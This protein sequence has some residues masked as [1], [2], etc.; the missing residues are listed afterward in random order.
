MRH[1][2]GRGLEAYLRQLV[3]EAV[4]E[5]LDAQGDI[6]SAVAASVSAKL[7]DPRV[8]LRVNNASKQEQATV[9]LKV[10]QFLDALGELAPNGN[11]EAALPHVEGMD[12]IDL[13]DRMAAASPTA[14]RVLLDAGADQVV[15]S[16][17]AAVA[18]A[19]EGTPPSQ[20]ELA[21][22]LS[23]G[24]C[25]PEA[26]RAVEEC[27]APILNLDVDDVRLTGWAYGSMVL[28]VKGRATHIAAHAVREALREA[29][30][31]RKLRNPLARLLKAYDDTRPVQA[32]ANLGREYRILPTNIAQLDV[33]THPRG[34]QLAKFYAPAMHRPAGA[35]GRGQL[36]LP[37]F[38]IEGVTGPALPLV[39]YG[40][41]E[42]NPQRGGGRG[43][44][45][46]LRLFVEAI[47][48]TPLVARHDGR[49][50]MVQITLRELLGRLYPG[51]R[52]KPHEY[53]P[54]LM[55]S[56]E[57]LDKMDARIPWEDPETGR[58]GDRRVVAMGDIPRGPSALD[59]FVTVVVY[60]PPGAGVGPTVSPNLH[61]WGVRSGPAYNALLNLAY[62]WFEPGL[63][64]RPVHGGKHWVPS[65]NAED[66][67]ELTDV[68]VVS[69]TRPLSARS[70]R[71]NA[72]A[73]SWATLHELADA[74][75][76]RLEG[77]RAI[78]LNNVHPCGK[79]RSPVRFS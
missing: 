31:T 19:T 7:Q 45:L 12:R 39:L 22:W 38:G 30:K 18:A 48:A 46:A 6:Q 35:H 66:Y 29:A 5:A 24:R 61:I 70:Q 54:R 58:G 21:A 60:L 2:E 3:D 57:A 27:L 53:W 23:A 1:T 59:D 25:P 10:Q 20:R 73:D 51:R 55:A 62:R 79:G 37:G 32:T 63:T 34:R 47:L 40:L 13:A 68:V 52:P 11:L 33:E 9:G 72:V 76:F 71:R 75:E 15:K 65:T 17:D 78:A 4:V 36:W 42:D 50:V 49:P 8:K 43:A 28:W 44:P 67:P 74:G 56:G 16:A 26:L 69:I 77:R 41:G 64:R 14:V